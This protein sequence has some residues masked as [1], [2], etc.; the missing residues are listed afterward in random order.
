M[1]KPPTRADEVRMMSTQGS[2]RQPPTAKMTAIDLEDDNVRPDSWFAY[3]MPTQVGVELMGA[4]RYGFWE[5]QPSVEVDGDCI[6][7]TGRSDARTSP[8]ER[9]GEQTIVH[10]DGPGGDEPILVVPKTAVVSVL[11]AKAK[12]VEA[13]P[14]PIAQVQPS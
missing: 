6:V 8:T 1:T 2:R 7:V 10:D 9:M 3:V 14:F 5:R 12:H 13:S 4:G 11:L